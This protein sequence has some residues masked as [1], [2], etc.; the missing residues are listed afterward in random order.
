MIGPWRPGFVWGSL[1][2]E[3]VECAS[4]NA[5][6][7]KRAVTRIRALTTIRE[8]GSPA[9]DPETLP[10]FWRG[11][12]NR[13]AA[14]QDC[15]QWSGTRWL[16]PRKAL[17]QLSARH[18]TG[19]Q[20]W[21]SF[22]HEAAHLLLHSK[23]AVFVHEGQGHANRALD[24]EANEWAASFLIPVKAWDEFTQNCSLMERDVVGFAKE[25][26]IAPGIVVGRLQHEGL[27]PWS[28]LNHL[29][30]RLKWVEDASEPRRPQSVIPSPHDSLARYSSQALR[31]QLVGGDEEL[32]D[33]RVVGPAPSSEGPSASEGRRRSILLTRCGHPRSLSLLPSD[34]GLTAPRALR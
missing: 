15:P 12:G 9:G 6:E 11:G 23:K 1:E 26:G 24:I 30:T 32:V 29:K 22:F 17:I 21:F 14:T 28:Q 18:M 2:A 19:D 4:Y 3:G 8:H 7:F 5:S 33:H 13:Q 27:L 20:L 10:G 34:C 25:Q 31:R 16:T